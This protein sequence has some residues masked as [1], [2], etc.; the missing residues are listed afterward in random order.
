[1][2]TRHLDLVGKR[3]KCCDPFKLHEN[4]VTKGLRNVSEKARSG[5][6]S[7]ISNPITSCARLEGSE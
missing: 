3:K 1:M 2:T 5:H 7:C 4:L 6:R